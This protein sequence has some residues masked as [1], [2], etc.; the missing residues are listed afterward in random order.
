MAIYLACMAIT[1]PFFTI[2]VVCNDAL[3]TMRKNNLCVNLVFLHTGL[4]LFMMYVGGVIFGMWGMMA[5][6][7]IAN[8]IGCSISIFAARYHWKRFD[9]NSV[10]AS[11]A[12]PH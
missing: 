8:C 1:G 5:F 2:R 3:Q 9:V 10:D 11:K 6:N 12:V 7:I 4:K